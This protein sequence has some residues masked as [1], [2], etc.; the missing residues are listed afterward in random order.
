MEIRKGGCNP[1]LSAV[2]VSEICMYVEAGTNSQQLRS[3]SHVN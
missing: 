1:L 3:F 2:Y